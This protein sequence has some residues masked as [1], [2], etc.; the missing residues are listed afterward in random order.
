MEKYGY[1]LI[2]D[3][4]IYTLKL[5]G[6]IIYQGVDLDECLSFYNEVIDKNENSIVEVW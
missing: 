3:N 4:G 1:E 5:N 6:N 2:Y